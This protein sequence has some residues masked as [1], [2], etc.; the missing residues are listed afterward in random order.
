MCGVNRFGHVSA[1]VPPSIIRP[2]AE[3][4]DLSVVN[5]LESVHE[6]E[7]GEH[8]THSLLVGAG[9]ASLQSL[10]KHGNGSHLGPYYRI[11]G[12]L[13]ARLFMMGGPTP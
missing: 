13:V 12:P 9:G 8:S 4:R 3:A 1:F 2:F 10:E 6:H 11:A 5:Y 7:V